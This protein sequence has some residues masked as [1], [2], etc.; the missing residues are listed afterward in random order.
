M[1]FIFPVGVQNR[2]LVQKVPVGTLQNT[3]NSLCFLIV[4]YSDSYYSYDGVF[5]S[6]VG[7][8]NRDLI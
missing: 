1:V 7:F 8:Q 4:Q 2:D 6:P 3:T 5:I